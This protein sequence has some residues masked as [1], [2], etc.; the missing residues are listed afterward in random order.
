MDYRPRRRWRPELETAENTVPLTWHQKAQCGTLMSRA[1]CEMSEI[2][3]G[4][5]VTGSLVHEN[6]T[7][8]KNRQWRIAQR[9]LAAQPDKL[10]PPAPGANPPVGPA[11]E[12]VP[13]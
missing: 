2:I 13:A 7:I 3:L 12:P 5:R 4:S 8:H 11:R 1:E 10:G 6:A 9:A